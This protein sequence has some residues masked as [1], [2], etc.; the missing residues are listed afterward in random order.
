MSRTSAESTHPGVRAA[1][2]SKAWLRA[3]QFRVLLFLFLWTLFASFAL[4]WL[5]KTGDDKANPASWVLHRGDSPQQP[6][7]ERARDWFRLVHLNFQRIYPWVLLGPYVAWLAFDFSLER[8]RLKWSL[9]IH[10][11]ACA[12]FLFASHMINEH[13]GMKVARIVVITTHHDSDERH[14]P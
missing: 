6:F 4:W 14:G 2:D 3:P 13:T 8:G 7:I 11:A 10:L 5:F 12:L 1:P 9:P